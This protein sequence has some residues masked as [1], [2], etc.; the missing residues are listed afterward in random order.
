MIAYREQQYLEQLKELQRT[1]STI[2]Q[3][4]EEIQR[5]EVIVNDALKEYYFYV[6]RR[7]TYKSPITKEIKSA[8]ITKVCHFCKNDVVVRIEYPNL[9]FDTV[10]LRELKFK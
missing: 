4:D 2:S 10:W 7:C 5:I 3:L 6:G 1:N 9:G 8:I